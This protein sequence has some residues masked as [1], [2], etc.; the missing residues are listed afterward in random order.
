M[1]TPTSNDLD[2][3]VINPMTEYR[4]QPASDD[5]ITKTG[6]V[7]LR[8]IAILSVA[9]IITATLSFG[10]QLW[11]NNQIIFVGTEH[12]R[13]TGFYRMNL[14]SGSPRLIVSGGISSPKW[15]PDGKRIVYVSAAGE[16]G[17]A[18]YHIATM[19]ADG[20]NTQQL[21]DGETRDYSPTWSPD[22]GQIAYVHAHDYSGGGPLAIFIMNSDGSGK[23]QVTPYAYYNDLSWSPDGRY[24]AY[25]TFVPDGIFV[26]DMDSYQSY[27]LTDQWTDSFPVWSPDGEYIAFQ[28]ARCDT[29]EHFDIYVM[30]SDGTDVR[31][32]TTDPAYDRRPSWSPDGKKILFE[33]NR[34]SEEYHIYVMNADGSK[35]RRVT[36]I[37]GNSPDW[38]P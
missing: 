34:D 10:Y 8:L 27:P 18:P 9:V 32:L 4:Y 29:N 25:F 37:V 2:R 35:K 3:W 22:G 7:R 20:T 5:K 16:H 1:I 24:I 15:S 19:N 23:E 33:S 17:S 11:R 28:S 12:G 26:L 30:R 13:S 6:V 21:T 14:L 38:R 31:R 36:E